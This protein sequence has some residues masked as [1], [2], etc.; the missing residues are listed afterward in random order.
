[1]PNS[2]SS[3]LQQSIRIVELIA[4]VES[5][6]DMFRVGRDVNETLALFARERKGIRNSVR[7]VDQFAALAG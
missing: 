6:I 4:S 5:K 1:M 7:C 2:L 3:S